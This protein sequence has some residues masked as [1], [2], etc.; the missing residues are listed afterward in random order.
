MRYPLLYQINTRVVLQEIGA[1]C[2]RPATLDDVE[3]RYFERIA[4]SGFQWI[5]FLGVWQTGEAARA[6][7]R[8]AGAQ[9]DSF[10]HTL[11]DLREEDI[12]GSP[13]AIKD[14]AVHQD[15]GGDA[16]LARLRERLARCGLHLL[17]DFVPHHVAPDHPWVFQHP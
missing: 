1:S 2:G 5:W 17:L 6:V 3:D 15:F 8:S 9:R 7:S 10:V 4:R 16:A 11:A 14:Y 12:T 13:F